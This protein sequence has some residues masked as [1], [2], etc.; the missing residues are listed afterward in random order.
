MKY[1]I[2]FG[3]AVS[4]FASPDAKYLLQRPAMNSSQ[5]HKPPYPDYNREVS[6]ANQTIT[7]DGH[8]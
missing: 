1:L 3:I 5:P 8:Q 4:A 7:G 6:A 2:F